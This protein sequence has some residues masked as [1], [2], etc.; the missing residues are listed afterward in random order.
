MDLPVEDYASF[1]E[2][3][4]LY[5]ADGPARVVVITCTDWNPERRSYDKRGVLIAT[6]AP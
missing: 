4:R 1:V 3:H 2:S 5:A 6:P